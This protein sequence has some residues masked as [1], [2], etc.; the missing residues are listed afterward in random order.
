MLVAI[1]IYTLIYARA[2]TRTLLEGRLPPCTGLVCS[3]L[4]A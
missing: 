3:D 4:T 1:G 2:C